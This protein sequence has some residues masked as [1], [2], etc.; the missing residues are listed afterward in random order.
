MAA[1]D[2]FA[3]EPLPPESPLWSMETCW[4]SAHTA[5][6]TKTWVAESVDFFIE[7]FDCWRAGKPLK[8]QSTN[9]P[10]IKRQLIDGLL[11]YAREAG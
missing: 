3:V 9:T 2:V 10:A 1:L 7:Q 6:H 11:D 4:I 8:T 5:D